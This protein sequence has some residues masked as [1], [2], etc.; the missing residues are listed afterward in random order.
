MPNPT[1]MPNP[2]PIV[3]PTVPP[4]A[5]INVV[6]VNAVPAVQGSS[7]VSMP[8]NNPSIPPPALG[9]AIGVSGS[10]GNGIG[11]VGTSQGNDAINGTSSSPL[12]AGVSGT[13]LSGGTGVW[14]K[15]ELPA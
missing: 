4:T 14:A 7:L 12:H 10:S 11:V 1:P 8:S 3:L 5:A 9:D 15:A 6:T 13:N 2:G